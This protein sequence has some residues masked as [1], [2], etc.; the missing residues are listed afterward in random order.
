MWARQNLKSFTINNFSLYVKGFIIFFVWSCQYA[1]RLKFISI[2]PP[3][4]R[5]QAFSPL[6]SLLGTYAIN[7]QIVEVYDRW[8]KELLICGL[9]SGSKWGNMLRIGH[10]RL[11]I[12]RF[13]LNFEFIIVM[14]GG[15]SI[16]IYNPY[17]RHSCWL[18]NWTN[19]IYLSY[20]TYLMIRINLINLHDIIGY[21]IC[22]YDSSNVCPFYSFFFG[23]WFI[24]TTS[25]C[26]S[27]C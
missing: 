4:I 17:W 14:S 13:Q 27:S 15:F 9:T 18:F 16:P 1:R 22:I 20:E 25:S 5:M 11:M 23:W 24:W 26:I 6:L 12:E 19:S 8:C 7:C 10:L 2:H 3:L 21:D